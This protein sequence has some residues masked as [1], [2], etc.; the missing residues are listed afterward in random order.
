MKKLK[1]LVSL[2]SDE[3]DYQREQSRVAN[4]A[5]QRF[6][7]D[8][9][10][11][12]A[13]G[14]SINQGQQILQAIQA[15]PTLRPDAVVCHPVGTGL[16]QVAQAAISAG[17]GW[18]VVNREVDYL[19]TLRASS[20]LPSFCIT[21]DQREIGRIQSRQ[22]AAFLPQGG[23]VL[24][25]QGPSGN[26]SVEERTHGMQTA[27]PTN[28]QVRMIRGRF[29][30]ESGY[31]AVKQWL[32][33]STSRQTPLDVVCSQNDAMALGARRAL[34]EENVFAQRL[35]FTGCDAAGQIGLDRVR[36]GILA[37]SIVLP[38]TAGLAVETFVNAFQSGFQPPEQ[39]VL[40]PT[41]F[42]P[43][44]QLVARRDTSTKVGSQSS[45]K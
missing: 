21:A 8:V 23:L 34:E 44:D 1:I 45:G 37:A 5:A 9:Q 11:I 27:K 40:K 12:Y 39:T 33:L 18:A 36:N 6:G 16:T 17:V 26:F 32:T 4:D 41:S 42:P 31:Q 43:I 3:N 30:E 2:V 24:Y 29:T 20:K 13:D 19:G 7:A 22:L 35:M 15:A 38:P 28:V 10:I 14:D 25:I